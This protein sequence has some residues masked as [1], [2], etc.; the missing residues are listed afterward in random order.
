MIFRNVFFAFATAFLLFS[1]SAA[2][3]DSG[4][5]VEKAAIL[6]LFDQ[7]NA[8]L[9]SGKPSS[10]AE[11]Y[12]PDA[13]LLPTV[14]NKVRH[15]TAEIEDYFKHFLELKPKGSIVEANVR[16]FGDL[17][18]NSGVY[19]FAVARDGKESDVMARFTFVY[20]RGADGKWLIVEHHSSAMP[21]AA[22]AAH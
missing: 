1:S 5:S 12:A 3:A 17:A 15:N 6:K 16:I 22:P 9:A 4:Q 10:V 19:K 7:W 8:S 20:K 14:S 11:N 2:W 13:I 21:E 18:I